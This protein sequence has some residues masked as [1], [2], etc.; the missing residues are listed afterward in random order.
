M[1]KRLL[2]LIIPVIILLTIIAIGQGLLRPMPPTIYTAVSNDGI[3]F[4]EGVEVMKGSTPEV[5]KLENGTYLM[6][7]VNPGEDKIRL[8][9]SD[10]GVHF[11]KIGVVLDK[12]G[13]YDKFGAI[14]PAIVKIRENYFR[15]YYIGKI[16]DAP[17][18]FTTNCLLTAVSSDGIHWKKDD[19]PILK[20]KGICDPTV[21][22]INNTYRIYYTVNNKLYAIDVDENNSIIKN[23][24]ELMEEVIGP[25]V[26][27]I[28]GKYRLYYTESKG[29]LEGAGIYVVESEDGIHFQNKTLVIKNYVAP[30]LVKENNT[31]RIY[32]HTIPIP[33]LVPALEDKVTFYITNLQVVKKILKMLS[34]LMQI[35]EIEFRLV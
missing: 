19:K 21:I 31:Y 2:I 9:V 18:E 16:E 5:I 35:I 14:D 33:I 13:I 17:T 3:K 4:S 1:K 25:F 24:G 32:Y 6:Y 11:R 23:W 8:A 12:G 20:A 29:P 27:R 10:D 30:C 7:Y 22:V 15:M 26:I 34:N 28:N